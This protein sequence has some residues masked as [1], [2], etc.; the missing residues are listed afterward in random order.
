M[1]ETNNSSDSSNSKPAPIKG[2]SGIRFTDRNGKT[3]V[4]GTQMVL[5]PNDTELGDFSV[6]RRSITTETPP[7]ATPPTQLPARDPQES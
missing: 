5:D 2:Y 1:S 4:L 7:T 3:I 6:R